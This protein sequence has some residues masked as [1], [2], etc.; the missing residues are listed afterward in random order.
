MEQ[1]KHY[2]GLTFKEETG[3]RLWFETPDGIPIA[4]KGKEDF[5]ETYKKHRRIEVKQWKE[6]ESEMLKALLEDCQNLNKIIQTMGEENFINSMAE[7]TLKYNKALEFW[8]DCTEE[9]ERIIAEYKSQIIYEDLSFGYA[10]ALLHDIWCIHIENL[11]GAN[12]KV[13]D[14]YLENGLEIEADTRVNM[15]LFDALNACYGLFVPDN[16]KISECIL[17]TL[18]SEEDMKLYTE[19]RAISSSFTEEKLTKEQEELS[20]RLAIKA[21]AKILQDV[22]KICEQLCK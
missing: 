3:T 12:E 21:K 10:N 16:V 13:L 18:F 19:I 22:L 7:C 14:K 4:F 11:I 2:S 20:A 5:I 9:E 1:N 15:D 8:D 17:S 6:N